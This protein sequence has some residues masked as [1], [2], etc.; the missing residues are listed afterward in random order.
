MMIEYLK[1][2]DFYQFEV[3]FFQAIKHSK[4]IYCHKKSLIYI[5]KRTSK[6]SRL[7]KFR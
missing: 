4:I 1:K 2:N 7:S 5:A 3:Y 6:F